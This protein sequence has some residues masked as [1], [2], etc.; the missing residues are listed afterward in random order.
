LPTT[1]IRSVWCSFFTFGPSLVITVPVWVFIIVIRLPKH[2]AQSLGILTAG[3]F[4]GFC[5]FFAG[6]ETRLCFTEDLTLTPGFFMAGCASS[7]RFDFR[8]SPAALRV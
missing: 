6:F 8:P 1:H 3:T 4:E 7:C 5:D 2:P